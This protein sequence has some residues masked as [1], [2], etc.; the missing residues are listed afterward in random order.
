MPLD[1]DD[2]TISDASVLFSDEEGLKPIVWDKNAAS[3]TGT[4]SLVGRALRAQ[5]PEI[6]RLIVRG[7]ERWVWVPMLT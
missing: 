6:H 4:L 3:I 5:H 7:G 2:T 1:A